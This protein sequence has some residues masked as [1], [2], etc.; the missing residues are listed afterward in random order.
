[1]NNIC[2][3]YL[4]YM[5]KCNLYEKVKW[6]RKQ[7]QHS[8]N[9]EEIIIWLQD[10]IKLCEN[11][12]HSEITEHMFIKSDEVTVKVTAKVTDEDCRIYS[13]E[14]QSENDL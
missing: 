11:P 14:W 3:L 10:L 9:F 6:F 13:W 12:R 1:M 2:D 5:G 7:E 4:K 8:K